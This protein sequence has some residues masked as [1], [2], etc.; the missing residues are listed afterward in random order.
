MFPF[1]S[2]WSWHAKTGYLHLV[3]AIDGHTDRFAQPYRKI[4]EKRAARLRVAVTARA[5]AFVLLNVGLIAT[6]VTWIASVLPALA[7][8]EGLVRR[9]ARALTGFS[10]LMTVT[11]LLLLRYLGQVQADII[12]AIAL[13]TGVRTNDHEADVDEAAAAELET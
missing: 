11:L 12:A 3:E 1:E 13:G 7:E 10:V 6:G 8:F 2:R 9:M 5:V 4:L